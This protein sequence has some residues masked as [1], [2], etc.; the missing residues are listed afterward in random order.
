MSLIA[1]SLLLVVTFWTAASCADNYSAHPAALAV[2]DE[3]V[4]EEGFDREELLAVFSEAQRKDKILEAM[5][6]PA[7][8]VKPW[9]EYRAI[10]LG[11]DRKGLVK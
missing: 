1:R 3:L 5:S 6:R 9:H 2:I 11:D 7:E 4:A 10:F 8:K